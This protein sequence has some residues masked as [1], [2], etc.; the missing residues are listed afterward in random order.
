MVRALRA[1]RNSDLW[2]SRSDDEDVSLP[3]VRERGKFHDLRVRFGLG[4]PDGRDHGL[5]EECALAN[6]L[7]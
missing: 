1:H 6:V 4:L 3:V 7:A 5:L 2:R